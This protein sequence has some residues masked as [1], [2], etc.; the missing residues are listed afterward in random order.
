MAKITSPTNSVF[1][2]A[3]FIGFKGIFASILITAISLSASR[4]INFALYSV[5][6]SP[7]V[8]VISSAFSI[9]WLFVTIYPSFEMITPEPSDLWIL[10]CLNWFQTGHQKIFWKMGH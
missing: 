1:E 8:I 10:F 3:S 9:T 7:I 5:V 4:P 6:S 2:S